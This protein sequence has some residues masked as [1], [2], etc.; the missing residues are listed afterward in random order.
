MNVEGMATFF[1]FVV[2]VVVAVATAIRCSYCLSI[3]SW[4][5]IVNELSAPVLP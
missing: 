4:L 2:V 1:F 5:G 3:V